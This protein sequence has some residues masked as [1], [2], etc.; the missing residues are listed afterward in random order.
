MSNCPALTPCT[1][2]LAIAGTVL[3]P[4]LFSPYCL[5]IF[6]MSLPGPQEFLITRGEYRQNKMF[7]DDA[8]G[9]YREL[10][11]KTIKIETPPDLAETRNSG[12]T[13]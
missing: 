2:S 10:G 4:A 5:K 11:K 1:Q 6:V 3:H 8:K 7:R 12:R 13:Y 9:F